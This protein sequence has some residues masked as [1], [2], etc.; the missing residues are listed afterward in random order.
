MVNRFG[1]RPLLGRGGRRSCPPQVAPTQYAGPQV[2]PTQQ[3]VQTNVLN[4]VVPHVHPS[5]TTVVNRH[6]IQHEHYFPH[7]QSVVNECCEN[8]VMCG[9]PHN[10]CP[11]AMYGY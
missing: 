6:M 7:T 9:C 3:Y 11:G 1:R 8:H 4:T 2:S 10:P 5:H